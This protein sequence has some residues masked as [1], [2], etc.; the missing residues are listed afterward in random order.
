MKVV[1][2]TALAV[3]IAGCA[4]QQA[5]PKPP[6]YAAAVGSEVD[7]RAFSGL[8]VGT[9]DAT[10][11]T[12]CGPIQFR[13]EPGGALFE[14]LAPSPRTVEWLKFSGGKVTGATAVWFDPARKADVYTMFEATLA[15]GVMQGDV[16]ENVAGKWTQVARFTATR[17]AD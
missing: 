13:L 7:Q 2:I 11:P 14:R 8:W 5:D 15:G 10:D 3:L 16:R 6:G 17:V 12:L 1:V 4:M 9:I